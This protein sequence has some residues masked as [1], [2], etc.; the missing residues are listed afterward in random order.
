VND[1]MNLE[2]R[3]SLITRNTAEIITKP[4]LKKLLEE[5][6][7]L[8]GYIGV[9]P[10]G[11]FHVGWMIWASKLKDM[12]DAGVKMRFFE[13]TWHAQINDKLN[14]SLENI[15]KCAKYLVHCL[16]ALGVDVKKL[17]IVDAEELISDKDYW[18]MVLKVSKRLTLARVRRAM[19]IMGRSNRDA[20]TDFAKLI[21]PAMQVSDIFYQDLD[22]CLGGMDQRRAHVLAI[23]VA[24]RVNMKKPVAVHTPL[25]SGLSGTGRMET[26]LSEDELVDIKMSKSKPETCIFIHDSPE[27]VERK[28]M[29]AYCPPRQLQANPII[30]I[31]KHIVLNRDDD[32]FKID[33]PKKYGGALDFESL[34]ILLD[35]Y[36]SGD[37]HPLDLKKATAQALNSQLEQVRK[38]FDSD[39]E[40]RKLYEDVKQLTVTR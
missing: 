40:A 18:G 15:K 29:N 13:A 25:L 20:A 19:T 37:V 35:M 30:E 33:R 9:E 12:V 26:K 24:D 34:D 39:H 22:L 21:Y 14:G 11:L 28:I 8:K 1:E 38:Y 27:D 23:E 4:R 7:Q 16:N 31:M 2:E 3:Y 5:K 32:A 17:K 36:R 10:S 6:R